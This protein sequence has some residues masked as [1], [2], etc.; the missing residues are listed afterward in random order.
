MILIRSS[1]FGTGVNEGVAYLKSNIFGIKILLS[2]SKN[3]QVLKP[4]INHQCTCH[5]L[6]IDQAADRVHRFLQMRSYSSSASKCDLHNK[7]KRLAN[8][9]YQV[10]F[11]KRKKYSYCFNP[12]NIV[13]SEEKY[14]Y[15]WQW[16]ICLCSNFIVLFY[17]L[18]ISIPFCSDRWCVYS[19]VALTE[20]FDGEARRLIKD[21]R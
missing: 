6:R 13:Y 3:N 11:K 15:L 16:K 9:L 12:N 17:L 10:L 8:I 5:L 1:I 7:R 21:L 19:R 2:I 20:K 4:T 14:P 18:Q